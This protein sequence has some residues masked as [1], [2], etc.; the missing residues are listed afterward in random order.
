MKGFND[1]INT[2]SD[3]QD[4]KAL[5]RLWDATAPYKSGYRPNVDEGHDM[6]MGKIRL[7]RDAGTKV[8]LF[9]RYKGIM[10]IAAAIA[11]LLVASV[12]F[13]KYGD[14]SIESIVT[15]EAEKKN[16]NLVDGTL[17]TLNGLSEL[18]FPAEF[19]DAERKV[20]LRGEGYFE[21]ERNEAHPFV[22][23]TKEALIS[24]LGTAFNVRSYDD[25]NLFEVFVNSGKVAVELKTLNEKIELS[26]GDLLK[27]NEKTG[28][29]EVI[30]DKNENALAW[31]SGT[32]KF[33]KQPIGKIFSAL[34]K[35]H[36]I[37]ITA[38][39]QD[40]TDCLYTFN[41]DAIDLDETIKSLKLGC[42]IE[43]TEISTGK[44]RV[45]GSCCE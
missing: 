17:V 9:A 21:V 8:V 41:T 26:K 35:L 12:L 45:T 13:N 10:R 2:H 20:E 32:L 14:G 40:L 6:F 24:V 39:S 25:E 1:W 30:S 4:T 22:V 31:K 16:L 29:Y 42:Q 7:D 5:E 18:A 34:E 36:H 38:E 44:Y 11:V 19:D 28:D 37:E 43:F 23:E 27:Y 3:E 15:N 33:N